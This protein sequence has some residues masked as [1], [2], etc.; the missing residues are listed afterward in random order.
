MHFSYRRISNAVEPN[1]SDTPDCRLGILNPTISQRIHLRRMSQAP[2]IPA[3]DG[4]HVGANGAFIPLTPHITCSFGKDHMD[5]DDRDGV[6][7]S[8]PTHLFS[9]K[10][11]SP[12]F[13]LQSGA[14]PTTTTV[15]M[16]A[17]KYST[18]PSLPR[19]SGP[20][21]LHQ[22]P[23]TASKTTREVRSV[24]GGTSA[25]ATG[26]HT[27]TSG[28]AIVPSP[29]MSR[30]EDNRHY[31]RW[32][33]A[34]SHRKSRGDEPRASERTTTPTSLA[35]SPQS[36]IPDPN[37]GDGGDG[38]VTAV[39]KRGAGSG[40][41][42]ADAASP[43][44]AINLSSAGSCSQHE[45]EPVSV[46][47]AAATRVVNSPNSDRDVTLGSRPLYSGT[48]NN[49][50]EKCSPSTRLDV[51]QSLFA[52]TSVS[53]SG[54]DSQAGPR[55]GGG[56]A[57]IDAER[58][59]DQQVA[60]L[61]EALA[62][63]TSGADDRENDDADV[64]ESLALE[65]NAA[66]ATSMVGGGYGGDDGRAHEYTTPVRMN[67]RQGVYGDGATCG[68]ADG[69]GGD[70]DFRVAANSVK[71]AFLPS[72]SVKRQVPTTTTHDRGESIGKQ[73]V[74]RVEGSEADGI[75]VFL[76][77]TAEPISFASDWGEVDKEG[78]RCSDEYLRDRAEERWDDDAERAGRR[79]PDSDQN[80]NEI[81]E[82]EVNKQEAFGTQHG[83]ATRFEIA[84]W[85]SYL[86]PAEEEKRR[87][88]LNV[89]YP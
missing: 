9:T 12:T 7:A 8:A 63:A 45:S 81:D 29:D 72:R 33:S 75:N 16:T 77:D 23:T 54:D 80:Q 50:G 49:R 76:E 43:T 21:Y 84:L 10:P 46:E 30:N 27:S 28:D 69:G 41:V 86:R 48:I 56:S 57:L 47:Q 40:P 78:L 37:D 51:L 89:F 71:P 19:T 34:P 31:E 1:V 4:F 35:C 42:T 60:K 61:R 55:N 66:P 15:A 52:S 25:H 11:E 65:N 32:R 14:I 44:D 53:G 26:G 2:L 88:Y 74:E 36:A 85:H 24:G 82:L 79:Q 64:F 70:G 13:E 62:D 73:R 6:G 58:D 22:T 38:G 83:I 3:S 5:Y 87:S 17:T 39:Q 18:S 20:N 67:Y 68:R 59:R